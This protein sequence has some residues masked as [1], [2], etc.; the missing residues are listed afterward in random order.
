MT[1]PIPLWI[2]EPTGAC[3][4]SLRRFRYRESDDGHWHNAAT[5]I[6]EDAPVTAPGPDGS[7]PAADGR[8]PH[9]DPRWPSHCACGEA[10]AGDDRWQVNE[11]DWHQGSGGRFAWGTGSWEGL[12]GAMIRAPWADREPDN[13]CPAYVIFLPNGSTWCTRDRAATPGA[14]LGPQW[15]VTGVPPLITVSPSIDDR[16]PSRPWHGWIRAGELVTVGS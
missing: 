12:P 3:R 8:I 7:K 4:L 16:D 9:D 1:S 10:F 13:G 15:T 14:A 5:V 2:A 11:L 6:D